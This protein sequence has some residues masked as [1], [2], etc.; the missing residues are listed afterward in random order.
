MKTSAG[1]GVLRLLFMDMG[2]EREF[3]MPYDHNDLVLRT[4]KMQEEFQTLKLI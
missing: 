1:R 2:E 3:V 4:K